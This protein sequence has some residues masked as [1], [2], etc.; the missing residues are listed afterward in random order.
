MCF[1]AFILL[2]VILWDFFF[3]LIVLLNTDILFNLFFLKIDSIWWDKF[4]CNFKYILINEIGLIKKNILIVGQIKKKSRVLRGGVGLRRAP[5]GEDG[6]RKFSLS[7]GDGAR[8]YHSG[9]GWRP[10]P[11]TPPRP[12]AIPNYPSFHAEYVSQLLT[13][14]MQIVGHKNSP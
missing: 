9:W 5:R 13:K 12:I 4:S 10:H 7:C 11:S 6:V 3:F 2:C 14:I 1:F 8:Q